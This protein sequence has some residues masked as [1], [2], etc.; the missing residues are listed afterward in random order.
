MRLARH[1]E[2]LGGQ[3]AGASGVGDREW[4]H[5]GFFIRLFPE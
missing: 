3:Q 5:E 2:Q 4:H 1:E